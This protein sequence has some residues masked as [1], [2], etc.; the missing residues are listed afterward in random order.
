MLILNSIFNFFKEYKSK[1]F[2]VIFLVI[3]D[4]VIDCRSRAKDKG[5]R[6]NV[7]EQLLKISAYPHLNTHY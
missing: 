7:K 1:E 6:I 4:L 3:I 5:G 2:Y